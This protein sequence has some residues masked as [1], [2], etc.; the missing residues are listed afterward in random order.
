MSEAPK[1]IWLAVDRKGRI[2]GVQCAHVE[3]CDEVKSAYHEYVLARAAPTVKPLEWRDLSESHSTAHA[4]FGAYYFIHRSRTG[5][6]WMA[7][8]VDRAGSNTL[9]YSESEEAAKAAAQADY[10]RRILS[11]LK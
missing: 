11:A 3:P 10:E 7:T 4:L 2:S 5:K 9:G 1:K 6:S 8:L